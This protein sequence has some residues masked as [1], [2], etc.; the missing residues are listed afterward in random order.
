ME[1][2]QLM[3]LLAQAQETLNDL[4]QA[5]DVQA[6]R[7]VVSMMQCALAAMPPDSP[8]R[9][10]ALTML[11]S[12]LS[13]GFALT[14]PDR[15]LIDD[16]IDTLS[17][18]SAGRDPYALMNL[19]DA[20]NLVVYDGQISVRDIVALR[21]PWAHLVY[22]SA[23]T[24]ASAGT[25]VP[26]ESM[27]L[28]SAFLLAGYTHVVGHSGRSTTSSR[29]GWPG[30]RTSCWLIGRQPTHC[31]RPPARSGPGFTTA[32]AVGPHSSTSVRSP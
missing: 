5:S 15:R 9:D 30:R 3:A 14:P 25:V 8:F 13:T 21:L 7:R 19:G 1:P 4:R 31:M 23:C 20:L 26:D 17:L 22:L 10:D 29:C 24:T 32:R 16:A 18:A 28:S 12:A 6:H 11:G 27:H 2:D